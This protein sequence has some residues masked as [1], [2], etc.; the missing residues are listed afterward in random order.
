MTSALA[1]LVVEGDDYG[2]E[3]EPGANNYE[4][5]QGIDYVWL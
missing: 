2:T 5:E 4:S 1:C 3:G